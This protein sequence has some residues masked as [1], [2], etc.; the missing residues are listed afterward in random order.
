MKTGQHRERIKQ[1]ATPAEALA[2]LRQVQAGG[3]PPRYV[4]RCE[5]AYNNIPPQRGRA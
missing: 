5:R 3:F 1:A 4:A 2:I